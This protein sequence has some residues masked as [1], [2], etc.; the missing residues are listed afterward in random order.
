MINMPHIAVNRKISLASSADK[1]RLYERSVQDTEASIEL[2]DSIFKR[3]R[4]RAPRS[5]REDFCGTAK[6]CADWVKAGPRRT[7]VGLDIDARTLAWAVKNNI[8]PLGT[9]KMRRVTVI[10]NDVLNYTGKIFDV[11]VAFNF[12]YFVFKKRPLLKKYFENVFQSLNNDGLFLLDVYGGPDAQ[13]VLKEETQHDGFVYI[14]DQS[15][16]DP[17]NNHIICHI[18]YRLEDGS[19]MRRAFTYDWRLWSI[20]ELRD[21]LEESGFQKIV[22]W[23]DGEDDILRPTTN[24]RNLVS[25][26]AYLAAWR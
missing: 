1:H 11:A 13:F 24:T 12:S 2:I 19:R 8:T 23:W 5:L 6:L 7:A 17:V 10:E 26:V 16:F 9:R 25:W 20:P 18:H 22:V 14:W 3:N 4:N 21:L 15:S